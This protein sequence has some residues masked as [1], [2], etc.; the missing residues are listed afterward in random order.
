MHP[1]HFEPYQYGQRHETGASLALQLYVTSSVQPK[2]EK[3]L[4]N[5]GAKEDGLGY[6]CIT[7][8]TN[9]LSVSR[10]LDCHPP[11]AEPAADLT[12]L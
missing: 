8:W 6:F 10:A 3:P 1:R 9:P 2:R 5:I 7:S 4:A 12:T 11:T